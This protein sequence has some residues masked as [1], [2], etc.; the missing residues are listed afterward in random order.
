M[1]VGSVVRPRLVE[2]AIELFG[3]HG[4]EGV[5]MRQLA[6]AAQTT[7]GTL[8]RLFSRKKQKVYEAAVREA[9]NRTLKGVAQSVFLLVDDAEREEAASRIGKALRAWYSSLGQNEARL[10][11]QV[12]I[13]DPKHRKLTRTPLEKMAEHLTR[14]LGQM[15]LEIKPSLLHEYAGG[16]VDALFRLK[17]SNYDDAEQRMEDRVNVFVALLRSK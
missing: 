9:V 2:A 5:N 1:V 15:R 6:K 12:E 17:I 3:V 10:L 14:I 16:V 4:Y 11:Q 8:Y 13:A 7:A